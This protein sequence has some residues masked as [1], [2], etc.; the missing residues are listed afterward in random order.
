MPENS[1]AGTD[2]G[3]P[4]PA[5]TDA[6]T[7]DTLEYSLEGEDARLF[8][9]DASTRQITTEANVTYNYEAT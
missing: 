5:A 7:G 8:D 1:A 4:I 9:F 3:D 2:V 6:D